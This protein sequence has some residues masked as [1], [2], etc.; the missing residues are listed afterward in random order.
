[1]APRPAARL[2]HA[3]AVALACA[4]AA[5]GCLLSLFGTAGPA[6][7]SPVP[8]PS[9]VAKAGPA[10]RPGA[11]T[12]PSSPT[13]DGTGHSPTDDGTA[14]S[15]ADDGQC[16]SHPPLFAACGEPGGFTPVGSAGGP[17]ADADLRWH[18]VAAAAAPQRPHASD[19]GTLRPDLHA[20]SISRT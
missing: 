11:A 12:P 20:L 3:V 14:P 17:P 5:A 18:T 4:L 10:G 7:A 13:A 15:S 6:D 2:R 9:A 8:D 1:M 16:P 19:P